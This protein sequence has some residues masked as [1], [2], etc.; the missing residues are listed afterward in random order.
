M[1]VLHILSDQHQAACMGCEGHAQALTPNMDR[2]AS[3]G[4]RFSAAYTQNPICTPSRMSMYTGQY[5]HNHGFFGLGGPRPEGMQ[6]FLG[7]FKRHGYKT[8]VIGKTHVPNQPRDW[9]L[10]H[11]DYWMSGTSTP[12][13][14]AGGLS[15][16]QTF[17]AGAGLL[18]QNDNFRITGY[19]ALHP[20]GLPQNQFRARPSDLPLEYNVESWCVDRAI[21]FMEGCEGDSFCMQVSLPRPHAPYTPDRKFWDMYADDIALP[22][23]YYQDPSG[24]PPHFRDMHARFQRAWEREEWSPEEGARNIWRGYLGCVTQVDNCIGRLLDYLDKRGLAEDTIVVYNS[25]HGAYSTAFGIQEKAPGICSEAVCRVPMLWRVPGV[26]VAGRVCDALVENVD[27]APTF[28]NLCGLP[29][30]EGMDG[31]DISE[32]L[33]GGTELVHEVAVTEHRHSKALR[34]DRWRYVHYQ[35]E[36]FGGDCGELYDL[37]ADPH[38]ARNLYGEQAYQEIVG[39]CEKL[40]CHWLI[41]TRQYRTAFS[42]GAWNE[43]NYA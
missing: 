10:D 43:A 15:P 18:E 29:A 35:P 4:M 1:N 32:L 2:L 41:S 31:A 36:N 24:R 26:A 25:D 13:P 3:K 14:A 37:E 17:L 27:L 9:L 6:S 19:P 42:V 30:M 12:V 8:A 22:E 40:L 34:W 5:C 21:E 23:T 38:E 16:Y 20:V 7:H 33:R 39:Q 28:M 11:V